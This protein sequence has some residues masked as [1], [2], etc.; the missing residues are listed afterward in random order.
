V[1]VS[2]QALPGGYPVINKKTTLDQLLLMARTADKYPLQPPDITGPAVSNPA[3][4]YCAHA[5]ISAIQKAAK[6]S[7]NSWEAKTLA[8]TA[9]REAMPPLT[10]PRNIRDFVACVGYGML[11]GAIHLNEGTK[12]LYAAQVA[13]I[14][15]RPQSRFTKKL[16]TKVEQSGTQEA[17]LEHTNST[18]N[19]T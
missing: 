14:T 17:I 16:N 10:G 5:Y 3:V 19:Q 7:K 18:L 6:E 9:F 2:N 12:L 15:N 13:Y 1:S 8:M 4:A 11:I